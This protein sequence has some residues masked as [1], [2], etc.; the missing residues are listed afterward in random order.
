[1]TARC[2]RS[3]DPVFVGDRVTLISLEETQRF[4]KMTGVT[5]EGKF[6]GFIAHPDREDDWSPQGI[7]APERKGKGYFIPA[8]QAKM[9]PPLPIIEQFD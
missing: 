7:W 5:R 4:P 1:M 2:A 3:G 9:A 8:E 6:L